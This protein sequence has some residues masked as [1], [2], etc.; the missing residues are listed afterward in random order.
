MI[1]AFP[2]VLYPLAI[3]KKKFI[4][5]YGGRSAGKSWFFAYKTIKKCADGIKCACVREVASSIDESMHELIRNTIFLLGVAGFTITNET[6]SHTSGGKIFFKGLKGSSK[7]ETR[8]RIKG[9][10][11]VGWVWSEESESMSQETFNVLVDTFIRKDGVQLG[12]TFNPYAS[13][14]AVYQFFVKKPNKKF[15]DVVYVNYWDNLPNLPKETIA[16]I[17]D[18]KKNDYPIWSHR[19]GGNIYQKLFRSMIS[20]EQIQNAVKRKIKVVGFEQKIVG[21][22]VA[23]YGDDKTVMYMRRGNCTVKKAVYEKQGIDETMDCCID[24][25]NGD[26]LHSEFII[27]DTGLSGLSDFLARAGYNVTG[28]TFSEKTIAEMWFNF[29]NKIDE[30]SLLPDDDEL[31]EE[32]AGRQYEYVRGVKKIESK[33]DFKARIMR[34]PDNADA[35]LLCYSDFGNR[36]QNLGNIL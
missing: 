36:M 14:D 1:N 19:Y 29:Q 23:R 26:I 17:E 34:S 35:M 2:H 11:D 25:V 27:D 21:V 8:T 3:S 7:A 12:F 5:A 30:I 18:L 15:C 32:L 31:Y 6:I 20:M 22:D 4:C 33:K 28:V 13:T 9:I 10:E 16:Y 24:F